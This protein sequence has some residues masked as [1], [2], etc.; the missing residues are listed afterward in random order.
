[1]FF[2][3]LNEA[4]IQFSNNEKSPF[5]ARDELHKYCIIAETNART[6]PDECM[7]NI[8]KSLEVLVRGIL[9]EASHVFSADPR[10]NENSL[11]SMIRICRQ[12][13]LIS[14]SVKED[15]HYLRTKANDIVHISFSNNG[16]KEYTIKGKSLSIE[17]T[18]EHLIKLFGV[19]NDVFKLGAEP[20]DAD[21][22]PIG[23]Y[24]IINK[25][26]KEPYEAIK[27]EYKYIAKKTE[28]GIATYAFIR[29]FDKFADISTKLFSERDAYTQL[30]LK[31][32]IGSEHIIK[33]SIIP[34]SNSCSYL[35]L[36]YDIFENTETLEDYK[37]TFT[38]KSAVNIVKQL[39]EGLLGL[40]SNPQI[41]IHHRSIR[42]S[43]VFLKHW[44]NGMFNAR[45][46]GFETAKIENSSIMVGTVLANLLDTQKNNVFVPPEV[47]NKSQEEL[48]DISWERVD[49]YSLAVILA[50]CL[51]RK[52]VVQDRID[53]DDYEDDFSEEF[54]DILND[55]LYNSLSLK[56]GINEF[57]DVLCTEERNL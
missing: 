25:I 7:I 32:M 54:I 21:F 2:D 30:Y 23:N 8:R 19:L 42:P 44:E 26:R 20:I 35:Y 57:Y 46:G 17:E 18:S 4:S 37:K 27:G 33:G 10:N 51:D 47:R 38:K 34:S 39:S 3:I 43:Y 52:S 53:F 6:N 56:P 14:Y 41:T 48:G 12:K 31:N 15:L 28:L 11:S 16:T 22:L 9:L 55:I 13:K 36:A 50:Y 1:M 40:C 45:L 5:G 29:P 24:E 49:V